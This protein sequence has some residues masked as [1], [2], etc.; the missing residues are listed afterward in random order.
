MPRSA[1][2]ARAERLSFEALQHQPFVLYGPGFALNPL[3]TGACREAGFTPHVAA[4]SSQVDFIIELVA[5]QLG[6]ALMPRMIA[7]QRPQP[8]TRRV[9]VDGPEIFWHMAL[10]W[11]RG[12]YLS[13]AAQAWLALA[14]DPEV[15][16][17]S[18]R[19]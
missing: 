17:T 18:E 15:R 3:I 8:L 7:Q 11:R 5:A 1:P 9:P 4:H 6:V 10:I 16:A 19:R 12:A 14:G 13:H 2:L